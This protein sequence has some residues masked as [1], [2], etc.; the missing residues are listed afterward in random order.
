[1]NLVREN[2][3]SRIEMIDDMDGDKMLVRFLRGISLACLVILLAHTGCEKTVTSFT[4]K[5]DSPDG[6]HRALLIEKDDFGGIDRNFDVFLEDLTSTSTKRRLLFTSPDEGK[7]I[8]TERF[9]W[10]IDGRFLL[11]VGM[12]FIV[13]ARGDS[14]D[15][16]ELL[17][18]LYDIESA[19]LR[20]NA[21]QTDK[22]ERFTLKDISKIRWAKN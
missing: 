22:Y 9:I 18:L 20:C 8:G 17:Y 10:S 15:S 16:G 21:S 11:L 12:K 4:T 1:M 19:N 2:W 3:A 7:P 6:R 5:C 14:L 13:V